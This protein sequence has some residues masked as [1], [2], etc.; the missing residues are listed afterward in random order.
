[1]CIPVVKSRWR[2]RHWSAPDRIVST[3]SEDAYNGNTEEPPNNV[4]LT[5]FADEIQPPTMVQTPY[6]FSNDLEDDLNEI[7]SPVNS[8]SKSCKAFGFT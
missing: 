2:V 7:I 1:M 8:C 6:F 4:N 3:L 5:S